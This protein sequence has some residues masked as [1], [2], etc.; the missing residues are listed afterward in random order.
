MRVFVAGGAGYIGSVTSKIL[1]EKNYWVFVYDNLSRGHRK[2]IPKGATFLR[3]DLSDKEGLISLF[4]K[5]RFNLVLHFASF[6]ENEFSFQRPYSFLRN[7]TETIFNLLAAMLSVG[8]EKIIFSS[9]AAV[10]GVPEK[11]PLTE[12]CSTRPISPYGESKRLVEEILEGYSRWCGIRYASLRYFN[13]GGAYGELGEDHKPETHLIPLILKTALGKKK[14]FKIFGDDYK[15]RDGTCVRDYIHI[16]DL[17]QAHILAIDAL[18]QGNKIYNLG[19]EQ[20]WTVKEVFERCQAITGREIPY[21]VVGRRV[22]DIPILIASSEK[23]KKELAW[24]P[25]MSDLDT[26]IRSAWE[27]HK[28]HP[29]GYGD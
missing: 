22:G 17:A 28:A 3:G 24:R 9:S 14:K 21:E 16:Y 11:L 1:L 15:T 23:I 13:A 4:K 8:C 19:S 20:G 5:Y 29:K 26:I 7:N 6:I 2:A 12:D 18:E 10:Y 25:E 27:W